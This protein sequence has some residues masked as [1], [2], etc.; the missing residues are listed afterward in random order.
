MKKNIIA[1][2]AVCFTLCLLYACKSLTHQS[3]STGSTK[4]P[5]VLV[6]TK[7]AGFY[8]QSIPVGRAAIYKLGQ[9]N[10]F[11]VD[12][13]SNA[14][15]FME[16][17]LKNYSAVVFLSTT[18]NVLNSEQQVAF[19]RYI[20]AGGG[21]V[22]IHAAADTEYDWPWFNKLVGA[23]FLSHPKQ[24][25]AVVQ[26]TDRTH[27]STSFLPQ[28]WERFDEWY[29]YKSIQPGIKVLAT[30]D[31]TTYEGGANGSN[32]PI[33]WYQTFDGGRAFYTGGGHTD[34]S[35]SEPLFMKHVLEGIKYAIGNNQLDYSKAYAVKTP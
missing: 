30:L 16:D 33:A 32:H 27:P 8:H 12:T 29:N 31:E 21:F 11:R 4:T 18:E 28:R 3:G 25:K 5:R 19:E 9:E 1:I 15:Y 10:N 22:G 26:V 20:Q 7:T 13:T 14:A 2:I 34:E 23:Y 6:F 17:S 35:Y 24:Q